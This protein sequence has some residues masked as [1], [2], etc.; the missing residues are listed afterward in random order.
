M[1]EEIWKDIKGYEGRYQVSNMGRVRSIDR[2]IVDNIGRPH[3]FKGVLIKP[4]LNKKDG[5]LRVG[6]RH[7]K[8]NRKHYRVNRLVALHFCTGYKDGL[9]VNHINEIK[10]DN[11]A[12]NLEWCT[13]KQNINHGTWRIKHHGRYP[14]RGIQQFK[15]D[16]LIGTYKSISEASEKTGVNK[17]SIYNVCYGYSDEASGYIWK[18]I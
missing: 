17:L 8:D 16:I 14:Q 18:F 6:L 9:D 5:Y 1:M 4:R 15:N 13:R 12:E 7:G 3:P 11:R 2:V 10:T